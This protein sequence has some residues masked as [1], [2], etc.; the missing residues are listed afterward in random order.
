MDFP[1][2]TCFRRCGLIRWPQGD[3]IAELLKPTGV[4]AL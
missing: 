1:D 2:D 3:G 4:V